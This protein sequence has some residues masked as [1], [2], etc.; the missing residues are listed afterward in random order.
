MLSDTGTQKSSQEILDWTK[1][2]GKSSDPLPYVPKFE[3]LADR[4]SG[5]VVRVSTL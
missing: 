5:L 1:E 4:R 3:P 2:N